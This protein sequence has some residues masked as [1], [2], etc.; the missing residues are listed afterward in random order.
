[1]SALAPELHL[2]QQSTGFAAMLV[3][4][5]DEM[6]SHLLQTNGYVGYALTRMVHESH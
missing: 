1:M 5:D 6:E 2:R 4:Q 3:H